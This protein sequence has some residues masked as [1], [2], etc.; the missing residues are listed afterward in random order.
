MINALSSGVIQGTSLR[1]T[2]TFFRDIKM[3]RPVIMVSLNTHSR[4]SQV[5]NLM[6]TKG[7]TN[8]EYPDND[9]A[10]LCDFY[11]CLVFKMIL[12]VDFVYLTLVFGWT[13]IE[14]WTIQK[15]GHLKPFCCKLRR[16]SIIRSLAFLKP[17]QVFASHRNPLPFFV[18][19]RHIRKTRIRF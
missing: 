4:S 7:R 6:M 14:G 10:Q 13:S 18:K 8:L 2:S 15:K 1:L 3:S 16:E 11:A 17:P 5:N 12:L 19:N 9:L